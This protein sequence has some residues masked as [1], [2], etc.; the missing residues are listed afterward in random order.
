MHNLFNHPGQIV[1]NNPISGKV[2]WRSPSNI[3]IVKY[4]GKFSEQL[5][6]NPSLSFTLSNAY[7]ETVIEF[8]PK[9]ADGNIR[10]EL[11]FEGKKAP[12]FENRIIKFFNSIQRIFPFLDQL[13][14]KINSRNSFPHSSGIASSA[15]SM[16]A[17][18]L[19]LC[20]IEEMLFQN[21]MEPK[22]QFYKKASFVSRIGSGSACRSIYPMMSMWGELENKSE[23]SNYFAIP[24]YKKE[25]HPSFLTF[26]DDILIVSGATKKVSSSVGHELM[27]RNIYAASRFQQAKQRTQRLVEV[28]ASGDLDEFGKITESEA[29]T[30]HALMMTSDPAYILIEPNSLKI[31][32]KVLSFRE[33]TRLP[34]F[35]TLDAGPNIHLLYPDFISNK[36][37]KFIQE[38]LL[39]YCENGIVLHDYLGNGPFP[40]NELDLNEAEA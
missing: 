39:E 10:V 23:S 15:S 1:N 34:V 31:I 29:L 6:Q 12:S 17:L 3:A 14:F 26:K 11:L 18:S 40:L 8:F 25:I 24:I 35:Y 27:E 9:K 38:E 28:L 2:G 20:S 4:W 22:E 32:N 5:P 33:E 36:I 21:A 7:T 19:C 13:N 16:S 30:L 37:E